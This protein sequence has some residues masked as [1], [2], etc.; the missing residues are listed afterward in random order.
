[1]LTIT[2]EWNSA[3]PGACAGV[4]VI[5]GADN[6]ASHVEL[7]QRKAELEAQLRADFQDKAITNETL[8]IYTKHYKRFKKTYHVKLQIKSIVQKGKSIPDVQALVQAMFMAEM[9][10]MLLTAG[11]DLDKLNLPLVLD[12]SIGDETYTLMRGTEQQLKAG[13]MY[14]R[15]RGGILSDVIY[16]P[17]KRS[18]IDPDTRNAVYTVYAPE[19]IPQQAVLDH[20]QDMAD[21]VR[22]ASP[23][24]KIELM[25]VYS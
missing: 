2:P 5:R 12:V 25:Q 3:F 10:N 23:N 4:L 13:D 22:I 24:A 15:D 9:K 7:A 6:P 20:L 8:E 14:I 19:G 11:H 18:S 16:G 21:Y 17:D 1:M